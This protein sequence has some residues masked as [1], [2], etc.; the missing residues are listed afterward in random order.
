MQDDFVFQGITEE[1]QAKTFFNAHALRLKDFIKEKAYT[2]LQ[3]LG[4][5]LST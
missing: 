3:K 4:L 2:V 1:K 5:E